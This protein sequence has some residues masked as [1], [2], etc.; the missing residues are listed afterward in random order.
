MSEHVIDYK[1]VVK[2]FYEEV[3][4]QQRID[5]VSEL[6][7][8]DLQFQGSLGTQCNG[9]ACFIRYVSSIHASLSDYSCKIEDLIVDSAQQKVFAKMCFQ[10][11]HTGKFLGVPASQQTL[12]WAGAALFCFRGDK[13][14]TLWVLGDL[15]QLELQLAQ[16]SKTLADN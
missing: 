12:S 7:H 9:H 8:E 16:E 13:I 2:R 10:G 6:L 5:V 1:T 11:R 15:K 4:E 14:A 3:W